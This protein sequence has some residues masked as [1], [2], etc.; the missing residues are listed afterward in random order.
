MPAYELPPYIEDLSPPDLRPAVHAATNTARLIEVRLREAMAR[1]EH[2]TPALLADG[3]QAVASL[4]TLAME[5]M[6]RAEL[7]RDRI[8]DLVGRAE[9]L[10]SQL[11]AG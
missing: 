9:A 11:R 6:V 4:L 10:A 3:L 7:A 5:M 2:P 1:G 8:E